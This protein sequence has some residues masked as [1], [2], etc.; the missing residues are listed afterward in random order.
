[1]PAVDS[2]RPNETGFQRFVYPTVMCWLFPH[3]DVF[4]LYISLYSIS[5]PCTFRVSVN[6]AFLFNLYLFFGAVIYSISIGFDTLAQYKPD[7]K[8]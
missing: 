7:K 4:V 5:R 2:K 8:Q 3:A 1:M 6:V